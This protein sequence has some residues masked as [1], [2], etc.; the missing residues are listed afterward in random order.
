MSQS[1]DIY[2]SVP[3]LCYF[4][5]L[6]KPLFFNTRERF[7]SHVI[8]QFE[9]FRPQPLEV[10]CFFYGDSFGTHHSLS[11]FLNLLTTFTYSNSIATLTL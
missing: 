6:I 5:H 8:A 4:Q 10:F 2:R 9:L 3:I 11:V 7:I 1:F